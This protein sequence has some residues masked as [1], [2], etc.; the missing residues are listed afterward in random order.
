MT[1]NMGHFIAQNDIL[2]P[3]SALAGAVNLLACWICHEVI[4]KLGIES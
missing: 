3:E 4:C 1:L 2:A